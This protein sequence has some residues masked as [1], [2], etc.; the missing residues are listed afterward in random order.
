MSAPSRKRFGLTTF[1]ILFAI[2][3]TYLS[4]PKTPTQKEVTKE[5]S[6]STK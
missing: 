1:L 6:I 4:M 5:I 3:L 2:V